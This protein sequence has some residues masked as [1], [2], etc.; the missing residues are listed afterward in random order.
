[1][2][3]SSLYKSRFVLTLLTTH[4]KS[5][6]F[7]KCILSAILV[8]IVFRIYWFPSIR[9]SN[10]VSH[11]HASQGSFSYLNKVSL[12]LRAFVC[13]KSIMY[14][15]HSLLRLGR[16]NDHHSCRQRLKNLPFLQLNFLNL[17]KEISLKKT[18]QK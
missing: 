15:P 4:V 1:M 2:E 16:Q 9:S 13:Q 12:H 11:L 6:A 10:Y 5:C 7:D 14:N 3:F 8:I 18:K 17:D